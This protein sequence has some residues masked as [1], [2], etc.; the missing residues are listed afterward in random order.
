MARTAPVPNIPAPP[1]MNPGAFVAGGGGDGGGAGGKGG[2]N[3]NGEEGAGTGDGDDDANGDGNCGGAAGTACN[4]HE[5]NPAA[6]DPIELSTG[7]VF[8]VPVTDLYLPGPLPFVFKRQYS[9][10]SAGLDRGLGYGWSHSFAWR[11]HRVKKTLVVHA[12]EDRIVACAF[13]PDSGLAVTTDLGWRVW[14]DGGSV[15]VDAMDGVR[16]FFRRLGSH[17]DYVL[18]RV[19]DINGNAISLEH[20]EQGLLVA[21]LDSVGRQIRF[22]RHSTGQ[23][24]TLDVYDAG[25]SRWVTFTRYRYVQSELTETSNADGDT[26]RFDYT[27]GHLLSRHGLPSG[28]IFHYRYLPDRRCFESWG[29]YGSSPDPSLADGLPT[30][31]ADGTTKARGV[32]HVKIDYG[33]DGY[34]EVVDSLQVYRYEVGAAGAEMTS[35]SGGVTTR[36]FDERRNL[37]SRTEPDGATTRYEYDE[38][39]RVTAIVNPDGARWETAYDRRGLPIEETL[40]DGGVWQYERD[41]AG[42]IAASIDPC[43]NRTGFQRDARGLITHRYTPNGGR[44]ESEYDA[45]GNVVRHRQENG[46]ER[47]FEY[48]FFGRLLVVHGA[49]GETVRAGYSAF[50]RQTSVADADGSVHNYT[51]DSGGRIATW[52]LPNKHRYRF[53]YGGQDRLVAVGYPSGDVQR[54]RYDREGRC[55]EAWNEAGEV[56]RAALSLSGRPEVESFFDGRRIQYSRDPHGRV[57]SQT[58]NS[59]DVTNFEYDVMGRL[60]RR[61]YSDGLVHEFEYDACGRPLAV[62]A[63]RIECRLERDAAGNV[64]AEHQSVDGDEITLRHEYDGYR[65]RTGTTSSLGSWSRVR[66]DASGVR[67]HSQAHDGLDVA[68]DLDASAGEVMRRFGAGGKLELA[69]DVVHQLRSLS[70]SGPEPKRAATPGVS[71][72]A[73]FIRTFEYTAAGELSLMGDPLNNSAIT[74]EYDGRRQLKDVTVNNTAREAFQYDAT[75]NVY[76]VTQHRKYSAGNKLVELQDWSLEHDGDSRVSE[77]SRAKD[78]VARETWSYEWNGDG[79][80]ARVVAPDGSTT[81]F[82]YDGMGRRVVKVHDHY[83]AW[84]GREATTTR[85]VWDGDLLVHELRQSSGG[86]EREERTFLYGDLGYTPWAMHVAQRDAE[87]VLSEGEWRYLIHDPFGTPLLVTDDAGNV[88]L[89][90]ER[91]AFGEMSLRGDAA[92]DFGVR[93]QGQWFDPETGLHYNRHRYYDPEA[94]RYLSPDPLGMKPGLNEFAYGNNPITDIDPFGLVHTARAWLDGVPVTNS[95]TGGG[96]DFNSGW[97]GRAGNQDSYLQGRSAAGATFGE[98]YR[99]SHSEFK[100]C[101]QLDPTGQ[102]NP[103]LSGRTLGSTARS[104][105]APTVRPSWS[106]LQSV[107]TCGWSTRRTKTTTSS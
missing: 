94:G 39:G 60:V 85:Y 74:F 28:L 19:V 45:H 18:E 81:S 59:G 86:T 1:G 35:A 16:R 3:G 49:R 24:S 70:V 37:I 9:S 72:S 98:L 69:F 90:F 4:I 84:G 76:P 12:G 101:R 80:L 88:L 56:F 61:E 68:H 103:N 93:F 95:Q 92:A 83:N 15:V 29:D 7:R 75:G 5:D 67:V 54:F 40:P 36:E 65:N 82:L 27:D 34:V 32:H 62:H 8:T 97:S 102:G 57:I 23:I 50:G 30:L 53:E 107:T 51:Y 38:R 87:G 2:K 105:R 64:V 104:V 17:Q 100:I 46:V 10:T 77:R 14:L 33:Q 44:T 31:L 106:A 58:L 99:A 6:G 55:I 26:T 21:A 20:D 11:L 96:L 42:N 22:G 47:R 25:S 63:P 13:P 79:T 89:E 43:G 48:D 71:A 41:A 52:E 78:D 73:N 91:T 66:R